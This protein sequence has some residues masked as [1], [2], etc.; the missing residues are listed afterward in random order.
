MKKISDRIV[1]K[2]ILKIRGK[3]TLE[4]K[5]IKKEILDFLLE[6]LSDF[7]NKEIKR[8]LDKHNERLN[9]ITSK[10]NWH[11]WL[12]VKKKRYRGEMNKLKGEKKVL[13]KMENN[14]SG[15]RGSIT[16]NIVDNFVK[17]DSIVI[18][19]HIRGYLCRKELIS[20]K[21]GMTLDNVIEYIKGYNKLLRVQEEVNQRLT[22]KKIR[23]INYP[24]EITEN[25]A[26]FA[27]SKKYNIMGDWDIKPG[28]LNVL[29]KQIEV[30]G[31]FIENGPPTFG[32]DEKWD[33]IY[34]VDCAETYNMKY[35]VYE[36]KKSNIDFHSLKVNRTETFGDH[37]NQGR[38]PRIVFS[39]IKE[40]FRESVK[41][42][43][44]GYI[45]ELNM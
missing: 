34:F 9:A 6:N 13:N 10:R 45:S 31:G 38:R 7:T 24:S 1:L 26:K 41:L 22:I 33:W 35:K 14:L 42:I 20:L 18:Q 28:D 3:K 19:K 2:E 37:C 25:I 36:I 8:I 11:T 44:D 29:T 40:Q 30:K 4:K 15:N 5:R 12:Y 23:K 21:D 39:S 17:I 27:I 16:P 43:F 32:P